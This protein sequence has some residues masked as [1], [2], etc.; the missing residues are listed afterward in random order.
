MNNKLEEMYR[1]INIEIKELNIE[2]RKTYNGKKV[3]IPTGRHAGRVGI[4]K[5]IHYDNGYII[6]LIPPINKN[7]KDKVIWD[8]YSRNYIEFNEIEKD[9]L[10]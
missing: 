9:I 2:L 5:D 7:N 1:N 10:N 8:N 6:C 3:I 4:I